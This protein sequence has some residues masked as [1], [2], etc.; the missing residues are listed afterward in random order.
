[1]SFQVPYI[2]GR[3]AGICGSSRQQL[4]GQREPIDRHHYVRKR[5]AA[6]D[7]FCLN[8]VDML[9][10]P[11]AAQRRGRDCRVGESGDVGKS[12]SKYAAFMKT[13]TCARRLDRSLRHSFVVDNPPKYFHRL[14]R[15]KNQPNSYGT[16]LSKVLGLVPFTYT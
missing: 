11:E 5:F 9:T 12:Q 13:P 2:L 16:N 7:L 3:A 14:L 8:L 15:R 6:V 1:M 10:S 4:L